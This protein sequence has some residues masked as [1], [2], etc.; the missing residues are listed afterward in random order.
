MAGE[1][2]KEFSFGKKPEMVLENR[3]DLPLRLEDLYDRE[4]RDVELGRYLK[5]P[6]NL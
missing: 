3:T 5:V 4:Y 2:L 1:A 6:V